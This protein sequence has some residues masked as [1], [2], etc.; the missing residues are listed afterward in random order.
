MAENRFREFVAYVIL[1]K[2]HTDAGTTNPQLLSAI[3]IANV[4]MM[5][6]LQATKTDVFLTPRLFRPFQL[7]LRSPLIIVLLSLSRY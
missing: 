3:S 4:G 6:V 5:C 1:Q 2:I 7:P